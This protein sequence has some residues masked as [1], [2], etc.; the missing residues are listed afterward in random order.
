MSFRFYITGLERI[1]TTLTLKQNGLDSQFTPKWGDCLGLTRT[2]M[3]PARLTVQCSAATDG[4]KPV[5]VLDTDGGP[6][7]IARGKNFTQMTRSSCLTF[8]IKLS[9]LLLSLHSRTF[10]VETSSRMT[11]SPRVH[12]KSR[13]K[14]AEILYCYVLGRCPVM[15]KIENTRKF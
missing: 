3:V 10:N 8:Y 7:C 4:S 1:F 2:W 11:T 13:F 12:S 5:R 14:L 9:F 6:Q 15:R